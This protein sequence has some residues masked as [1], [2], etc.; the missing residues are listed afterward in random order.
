[1][2]KPI[3]PQDYTCTF[4][5]LHPRTVIEHI[6]PWS[7]TWMLPALIIA[8]TVTMAVLAAMLSKWLIEDR[9]VRRERA[10]RIAAEEAERRHRLAIEEQRTLQMNEAKGDPETLKLMREILQ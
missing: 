6:G 2:T 7:H 4:T 8:W 9:R 10:E 1:M 5:P 3:C